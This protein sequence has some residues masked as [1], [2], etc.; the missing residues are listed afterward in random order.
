MTPMG[1]PLC[2][3][4]A[5]LLMGCCAPTA[6]AAGID[7]DALTLADF[8]FMP[9]ADEGFVEAYRVFLKARAGDQEEGAAI[10]TYGQ[11]A[12]AFA[13]VAD[14]APDPDM[15]LRCAWFTTF[16]RF[17]D[18]DLAG[19]A[20]A[21]S[22][23]RANAER[24]HPQETARLARIFQQADGEGTEGPGALVP[25]LRQENGED[26]A[27]SLEEEVAGKLAAILERRGRTG[28]ARQRLTTYELRTRLFDLGASREQLRTLAILAVFYREMSVNVAE[29]REK[30]N[31]ALCA[32]NLRH[33]G[34]CLHLYAQDN[35]GLFP[36]AYEAERRQVWQFKVFPYTGDASWSDR[37]AVWHCPSCAP[38]GYSYGINQ[39][40]SIRAQVFPAH[41]SRERITRPSETVLLADSVHYMPGDYPHRPNHGG[42][43]Y[44]IHAPKEHS[45]TGTVD[46][47]RHSG[48][49]NVL[50]VDGRVEWR[51]SPMRLEWVGR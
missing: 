40:I 7:P 27:P 33:L 31:Q 13:Q 24:S 9:G 11:A 20:Q 17:L 22:A 48:G 19:A 51:T 49:A 21:A 32:A 2:L 12:R 50:F 14:E 35:D 23:L 28:E 1:I 47:N 39:N 15:R 29:N 43:A 46:W 10:S 30:I 42:A 4:M 41:G 26:E 36:E 5:A 34:V 6:R 16:C 38:G 45:G 8:S 44:K 3:A 25:L 37:S 18:M